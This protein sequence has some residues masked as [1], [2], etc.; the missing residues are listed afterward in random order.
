M[1]PSAAID[2][3]VSGGRMKKVCE[4]VAMVVVVAGLCAMAGAQATAPTPQ[5]QAVPNQPAAGNQN[6]MSSDAMSPEAQAKL[7]NGVRHAILMLP[8]FGV[9][10]NLAFQLQGRTVILQ[11]QVLR[12]SLKP[13]AERAVK[14][15]EGVDNVINKIEVLPPGPIDQRIRE[16]V[17]QAIYSYGPLFKYSNN[18]IPPIRIIVKNARV[19]LEGVVNN[20]TDKGLCTLRANQV[21]DVLSVTNNLRVSKPS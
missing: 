15:V 3:L 19:T 12:S 14:K 17:R 20:E 13:D 2:E 7:V 1:Q 21:P 6:Q 8:Y 10:D 9:F 16:A 18:P 11:G 5:G 4:A